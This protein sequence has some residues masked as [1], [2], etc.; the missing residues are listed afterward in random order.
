MLTENINLRELGREIGRKEGMKEG[1]EDVANYFAGKIGFE[2]LVEKL[3]EEE[4]KKVKAIKE[5]R[6]ESKDVLKT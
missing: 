1:A 5:A 4:A 2:G 3:G 6:G